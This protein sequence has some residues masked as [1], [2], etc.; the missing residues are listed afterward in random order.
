M[1]DR[2]FCYGTLCV[3]EIM[4]QVIGREAPAIPAV[5][6]DYACHLVRD[7][8]YP[9]AVPATGCSATGLLYSG[10]TQNELLL[11]DRYEGAEYRRLR[12][13]VTTDEGRQARAW[14]YIIR[15]QYTARLS[16]QQFNLED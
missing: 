11:L 13:S 15:P 5:L 3:P 14:V 16:D 12:V 4:R 6:E 9:A 10:L 7:K 2:L 1:L 8:Y